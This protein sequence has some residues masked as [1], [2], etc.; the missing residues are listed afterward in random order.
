MGGIFAL[1]GYLFP[2]TEIH[3]E[4]EKTPIF[5]SHGVADPLIPLE[6]SK[7]SY[8]KLFEKTDRKTKTVW[9]PDLEHSVNENILKEF[10]TFF[11]DLFKAPPAPKPDL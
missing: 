4:N 6:L 7:L 1:S 11:E 9:E 2:I 10:K 3:K 5:F 8:K